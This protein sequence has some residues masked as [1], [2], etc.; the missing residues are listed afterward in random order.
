MKALVE[1]HFDDIDW[2]LAP[3]PVRA[4]AERY[5]AAADEL[6]RL[7]RVQERVGVQ[8]VALVAAVAAMATCGPLTL[9]SAVTPGVPLWILFGTFTAVGL[10]TVSCVAVDRIARRSEYRSLRSLEDVRDLRHASLKSLAAD[11]WVRAQVEAHEAKRAVRR[12][13]SRYSLAAELLERRAK[14]W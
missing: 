4:I 6:V 8:L 7:H 14:K 13:D 10:V 1:Y 11:S 2:E 3:A 5:A 9:M 12:Q